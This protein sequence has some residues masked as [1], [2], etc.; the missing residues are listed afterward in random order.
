MMTAVGVVREIE[1]GSITNFRATPVT[2]LEFLV[3][4]Q[5]PYI[6]I[7]L[8][9]FASMLIMILFVFD[10]SVK[11]S[12]I[13]LVTGATLYVIASTGFGLFV[14]SFTKSQIAAL[15]VTSAISIVPAIHFSGLLQIS[16]G[17]FTK[18]LGFEFLWHNH[19]VL[20]GF[21]IIFI[22]AAVIS[23]SKQEK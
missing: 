20:A 14:S 1:T 13:A 15:F 22:L 6:I 12:F 8:V 17:T 11:G 2:R 10:M 3:G 9:S 18:S 4:K 21:A 7:A 23:L 19:L 5:I 16:V